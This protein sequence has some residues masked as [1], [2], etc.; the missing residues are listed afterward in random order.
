MV[1]PFRTPLLQCLPL[2]CLL[3][4]LSPCVQADI[5]PKLENLV[6]NYFIVDIQGAGD[7]QILKEGQSQWV[8]AQVGSRLEEGDKISVGDDTEA[9]L[10]LKSET[11][12]HLDE[13]TEMSVAQLEENQAKGFL[14]RLELWG[15]SLLSDVKKRLKD[16]D[17]QFEVEAGGVVCGVRGTVFEVANNGGQVQASTDEGVV[18]V[19]T[20]R[21]SRQVVAGQTCSASQRGISSLRPSN[22]GTQERFRSWRHLHQRLSQKQGLKGKQEARLSKPIGAHPAPTR[23]GHNSA[24]GSGHPAG[25]H[26]APHPAFHASRG[27]HR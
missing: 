1:K 12:V 19:V 15:G 24:G 11:L 23:L 22:F 10:S 25:A 3:W 9:V 18:Q 26:G 14:S 6:T 8:R 2:A 16:S 27:G 13:G 4:A 5:E 17:S 20:P 7:I 21:G